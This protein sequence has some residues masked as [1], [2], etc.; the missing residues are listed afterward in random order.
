MGCFIR[1]TF[2]YR[3]VEAVQSIIVNAD[4][5]AAAKTYLRASIS[6]PLHA[7]W[8]KGVFKSLQLRLAVTWYG[9]ARAR[10]LNKGAKYYFSIHAFFRGLEMVSDGVIKGPAYY[11][12]Q[13]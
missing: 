6:K 9:L 10:V 8:L 3:Y 11:R 5:F 12:R 1:S 13:C 2:L 4:C 7:S